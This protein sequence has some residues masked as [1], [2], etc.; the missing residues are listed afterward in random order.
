MCGCVGMAGASNKQ[1]DNIM[2]TLLILDSLRG[3]DSTGIAAIMSDGNVTVAKQLGNAYELLGSHSYTKAMGRLNRAVIGHN[4][5]ATQGGVNKRNAHPFEFDTLVG[6][7]NGTL[8]NK[9]QLENAKD[10]T[11][12]SENL[13]HHIDKLGLHHAMGVAKGAWSLVW[14]DKVGETLNFLRNKERP[15]WMC[16]SEDEKT[17]FWASERWMLEIATSREGVKITECVTTDVDKK[18]SFFISEDRVIHKPVVSSHPSRAVEYQ[19]PPAIIPP[20]FVKRAET[21]LKLVE[22]T[23]PLV[24]KESIVLELLSTHKDRFGGEYYVCFDRNHPTHSIRLY[25][26]RNDQPQIIGSEILCDISPVKYTEAS[27]TGKDKVEYYKVI[28][29]SVIYSDIAE[30][31]EKEDDAA[32]NNSVE[33]FLNPKGNK[34]VS[35][36]WDAKHGTCAFCTGYVDPRADFRFTPEGESICHECVKDPELKMMLNIK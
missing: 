33:Y 4:R 19:M 10:F 34:I 21:P 26:G 13:Y 20:Q 7:H 2:N 11:V 15:M 28:N 27:S 5:Y 16:F 14:W 22:V 3:V 1:N 35:D 12:D 30:F 18:Y 31:E 24:D 6:V 36:D 8:T 17:M 9:W 25:I 23:T 29:S 32:T